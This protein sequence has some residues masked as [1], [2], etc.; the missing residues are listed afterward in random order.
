MKRT[1]LIMLPI[2]SV[3]LLVGACQAQDITVFG[4]RAGAP[5]DRGIHA[6]RIPIFRNNTWIRDIEF[7]LTKTLIREI[8][9]KTPWK[10][11]Q[12][13][14]A[15]AELTGTIQV[16][17]KRIIL[18][19]QIN[20]VREAEVSLEVE[21]V[22]RDLRVGAGLRDVVTPL[23]DTDGQPAFATPAEARALV[24]RSSPFV[25]ELGQS[26]SSARHRAIE[27]LATQIVSMLEAPW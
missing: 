8:E 25:P 27:D 19:S 23:A 11:V 24:K 26:T 3:C 5:Y 1:F 9:S 17:N 4:Y 2:L 10:V 6:I 13:G 14:P 22:F 20:E 18:Q 21:V 12:H 16:A 15:D 7:D